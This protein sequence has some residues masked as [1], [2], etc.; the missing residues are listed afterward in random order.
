MFHFVKTKSFIS[1]KQNIATKKS[2]YIKNESFIITRKSYT[3]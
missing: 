1:S 3:S 2:K